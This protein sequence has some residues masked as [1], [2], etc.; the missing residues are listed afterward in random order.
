MCLFRSK[1]LANAKTGGISSPAPTHALFPQNSLLALCIPI[2]SQRMRN[3]ALTPLRT[4]TATG[5]KLD[6]H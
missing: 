4:T 3:Q 5:R 6:I 2:L 1:S